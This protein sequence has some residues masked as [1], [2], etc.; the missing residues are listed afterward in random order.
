MAWFIPLTQGARCE[1]QNSLASPPTMR[2][3]SLQYF[4]A[5]CPSWSEKPDHPAQPEGFAGAGGTCAEA[6][7]AG[8]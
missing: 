3:P 6:D 8:L 2:H 7:T 4:E 1:K 5:N